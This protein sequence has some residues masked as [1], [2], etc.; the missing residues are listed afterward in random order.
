MISLACANQTVSGFQFL[1][2]PGESVGLCGCWWGLVSAGTAP[3]LRHG[4]GVAGALLVWRVP[5]CIGGC[6]VHI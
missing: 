3:A 2:L 6:K 5:D 4:A 1:C